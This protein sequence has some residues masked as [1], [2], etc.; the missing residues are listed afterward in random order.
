L[1]EAIRV[2]RANLLRSP[3]GISLQRDKGAPEER[4]VKDV[5]LSGL[6]A[7]HPFP[8]LGVDEAKIGSNRLGMGALSCVYDDRSQSAIQAQGDPPPLRGNID[9]TARFINGV[10]RKRKE[11]IGTPQSVSPV[12]A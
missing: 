2:F 11:I 6:A 4:I 1:E 10:Q 7:N 3:P 9:F 8:L 5:T 12:A